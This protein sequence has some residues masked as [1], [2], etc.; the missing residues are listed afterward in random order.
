MAP[1]SGQR[2]LQALLN[3]ETRNASRR[4]SLVFLE[5]FSGTGRLAQAVRALRYAAVALDS[6]HGDWHILRPVVKNTLRWVSTG[7]AA[8]LWMGTPCTAWSRARHGP[9]R[10][11]WAPL[12][13]SQQPEGFTDLPARDAQKVQLGNATRIFTVWMVRLCCKVG[14]LVF[15][16][17]PVSSTIGSQPP[18]AGS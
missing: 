11:P 15:V 1:A 14:V 6:N 8:A 10:T 18:C 3:K 5:L 13:S 7:A 12:R 9:P 2:R 17:N 16:G 4:R